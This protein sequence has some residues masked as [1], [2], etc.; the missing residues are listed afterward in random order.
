MGGCLI[1]EAVLIPM[2]MLI[3]DGLLLAWLLVELRN[4]GLDLGGEERLDSYQAIALLP[5]AALACAV[6]LPARYVATFV[7]LAQAHLP[8]SVYSTALGDYIRWQ[9]GWGLTDLQAAALVL[10]GLVG[11]VAWTRGRIG[12]S[13]AGY[14]RL[15]RADGGHVIVALAMAAIAATALS[16]AAYA[17]VLLLPVQTWVLGAADAYAHFATLPVGLWTLAALIEL[18]GRSLPMATLA[19]PPMRQAHAD[20][21]SETEPAHQVALPTVA[22]RVS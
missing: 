9:L 18:A 2:T 6:A 20:G 11:A 8:T 5:G 13:I 12:E 4:A 7:F 21:E 19:Q 14:W 15:L 10:V 17:I 1:V 16:A 3:V 22:A